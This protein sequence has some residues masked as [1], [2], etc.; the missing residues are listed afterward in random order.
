V[1]LKGE[2]FVI[3][4]PAEHGGNESF[5]KVSFL[6]LF[7]IILYQIRNVMK[8]SA[9]QVFV[10]FSLKIWRAPLPRRKSIPEI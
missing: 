3:E 2:A 10:M 1:A 7:S 9:D 6:K 8:T 5:V 4:R